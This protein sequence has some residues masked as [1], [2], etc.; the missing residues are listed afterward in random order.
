MSAQR[1]KRETQRLKTRNLIMQYRLPGR[2]TTYTGE[3]INMSAGG[4]CFLRQG[5]IDKGTTIQIRFPAIAKKIILSGTV[6]RIDGRETSVKFTTDEK[7]IEQFIAEFNRFY[8]LSKK[9]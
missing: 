2:D 5:L 8:A 9:E 7:E 3:V 6:I 1:D 4:L